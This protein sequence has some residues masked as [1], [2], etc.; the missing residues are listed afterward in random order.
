VGR[1]T[2]FKPPNAT[3][4]QTVGSKATRYHICEI[5]EK[6]KDYFKFTEQHNYIIT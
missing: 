4:L 2:S 6:L 1:E 3:N 5:F